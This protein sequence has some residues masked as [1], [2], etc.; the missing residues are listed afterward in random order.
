LDIDEALKRCFGYDRFRPCQRE[1]IERVMAGEDVLGIL[2]TGAGKSLCYQLPSQLL[3]GP[4][5][6]IS[7]LIAL[8]KDQLDGLPAAVYPTATLL[9]SS[10]ERS[11]MDRRMAEIDSGRV[12]LIYAAP[13]RLRQRGFLNLLQRVG[14]SLV[15]VDE[16]H[17]VSVWGHDFRPDYLFIRKALAGLREAGHNPTLLAVTA[18][19]TPRM[20]AE[21]AEQLGRTM[22]TVAASSFRPNLR[23]EVRLCASADDK[24]RLLA[25]ACKES[26]GATIVYANSRERSEQLAAYLRK[27][28]IR[29]AYY[30]AGMEQEERRQAQEEFMLDRTRVMVATIAFGMGVDKANVRMVAHFNPPHSLESY[31]QEAGRAGRDGK[32]SRCLLLYGSADKTNLGRWLRRDEM[33]LDAVRAVYRA[34]QARIARNAT[35]EVSPESLRWAAFGA[36]ADPRETDTTLRVAISMLERAGLVAR[37]PDAGG[38]LTIRMLRPPASARADLESILAERSRRGQERLDAVVGYVSEPGCRHAAV[39][40][41]LGQEI[42]PCGDACDNCLGFKQAAPATKP[43]APTVEEVPDLGRVILQAASDLPFRIGR[44]GLAKL[45]SGAADSPVRR[46]ASASYGVLAGFT[47]KALIE[48]IDALCARDLLRLTAQTEYPLLQITPEG[49]TA[50]ASEET[51]S[52]NPKGPARASAG[53]TADGRIGGL[54]RSLEEAL[55]VAVPFTEDEEDRFERLRAWRRAEAQRQGVPAFHVFTD[56]VLRAIAQGNPRS[57]EALRGIKGLGELNTGKYGEQVIEV[58]CGGG[59]PE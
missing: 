45:L 52:V 18:T 30:H 33:K 47:R 27:E 57:I 38:D 15:V 2:P 14:P 1:I 4:T 51:I 21:I 49:R 7:P 10:V 37:L 31:V 39:A 17:C 56:R 23:F 32:P 16:A 3:A 50:L 6:V 54:E 25:R 8:M 44:T 20:A 36:E 59:D 24:M 22:E 41:H 43:S 5:I 26:V 29:A 12:K 46:E 58:L 40:R 11:E 35:A 55:A 19:A 42:D 13:E 34:L 9:N 48:Q 28:G 53:G